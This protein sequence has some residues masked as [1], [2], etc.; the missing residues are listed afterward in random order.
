[1]DLGSVGSQV[2]Q[3]GVSFGR[4]LFRG[5]RRPLAGWASKP[6][7]RRVVIVRSRIDDAVARVIVRPKVWRLRIVPECELQ[8]PHPGK[9]EFVAE[10]LDRRSDHTQVLGDERHLSELLENA[11]KERLAGTCRP[12][13]AGRCRRPGRNLPKRFESAKVIQPD[14]IELLERVADAR[15]PPGVPVPLHRVPAI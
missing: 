10:R 1:M 12:A 2:S 11:L 7:D 6:A 9:T 14:Q 13:A 5:A 3:G 4:H 15:E 8:D